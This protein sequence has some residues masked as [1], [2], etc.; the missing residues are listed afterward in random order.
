M[1]EVKKVSKAHTIYKSAD[2]KRLPGTTTIL[3]ILNKPALVSWANK[4]G[5]DGI[6][7]SKYVDTA[8]RIGTLAHYLVQCDL[9]GDEPD[10]SEYG[11]METSQAENALLS[12]Y[13]W[14]KTKA[15]FALETEL[16]LVSEKYGYGGTIDCYC[17]LGSEYWLLDFK[18]GKAIYPEML[19]QLAAYRNLLMENGYKVEKARILR[20][21][22]DET[23]GFE[24]RSISDFEPY[25]KIFEHC[26]AI[27]NLQKEIKG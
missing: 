3:G 6:D 7:S 18:T 25:W 21:G 19:I 23:E 4:L 24:E 10:T 14:K 22:R 13:E 8:A 26:L 20:I 11:E 16:P 9:T 27:Y 5:L 17:L 15:I 2:G 12:Y 1:D